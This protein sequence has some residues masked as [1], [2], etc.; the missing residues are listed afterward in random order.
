MKNVKK[1]EIKL[2]KDTKIY[3]N[4]ACFITILIIGYFIL[5]KVLLGSISSLF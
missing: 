3:F 2:E 5:S 1:I 4:L